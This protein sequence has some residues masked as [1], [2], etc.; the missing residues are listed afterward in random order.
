MSFL[1]RWLFRR[2]TD[3]ESGKHE[4]AGLFD[5]LRVDTEEKEL[6]FA[7]DMQ[8]QARE[9]KERLCRLQRELENI[10]NK[11]TPQTKNGGRQQARAGEL[12]Q[13]IAGLQKEI[14]EIEDILTGL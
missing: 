6:P 9:M 13:E 3:T 1:R 10:E 11:E 12:R 4:G 7:G 5:L 8:L 2:D 14:S